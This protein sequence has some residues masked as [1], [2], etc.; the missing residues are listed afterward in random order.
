LS[1]GVVSEGTAGAEDR[2]QAVPVAG[3]AAELAHDGRLVLGEAGEAGQRK[4]GVRCQPERGKQ[5][6]VLPGAKRQQGPL[7]AWHVRKAHPG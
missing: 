7:G 6:L 4:V 5:P 2:Q 3:V 1:I